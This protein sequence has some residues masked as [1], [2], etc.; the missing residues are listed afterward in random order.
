MHAEDCQRVPSLDVCERDKQTVKPASHVK[1]GR[2][3]EIAIV[4]AACR[5][6]PVMTT[7][8]NTG[9]LLRSPLGTAGDGD[10]KG[11]LPQS[12]NW[13]A[14]GLALTG[15]L[16]APKAAHP[17]VGADAPCAACVQSQDCLSAEFAQLSCLSC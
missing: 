14:G 13:E 3:Q 11:L 17:T 8:L 5:D 2:S 6:P 7:V 15:G 4:W 1:V 12:G 16:P 10:A 9:A